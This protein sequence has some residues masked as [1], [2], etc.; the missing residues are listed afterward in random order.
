MDGFYVGTVGAYD[1]AAIRS[2]LNVFSLLAR[3]SIDAR[4]KEVLASNSRKLQKLDPTIF[5]SLPTTVVSVLGHRSSLHENICEN[6]NT[7]RGA[8]GNHCLV[9]F[10]IQL[11][12]F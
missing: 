7:H 5:A 4:S 11:L 12:Q 1:M 6:E 9:L 10:P 2:T 8:I 3:D